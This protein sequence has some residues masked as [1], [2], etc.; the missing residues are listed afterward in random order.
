MHKNNK[1]SITNALKVNPYI[2]YF[3]KFKHLT[4]SPTQ[5]SAFSDALILLNLIQEIKDFSIGG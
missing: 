2:E 4:P 1:I 5:L 3:S